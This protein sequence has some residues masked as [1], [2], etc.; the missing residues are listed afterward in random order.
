MPIITAD[1]SFQSEL[2]CP[3]DWQPEC[4]VTWL[5]DPDGDGTFELSLNGLPAGSYG[6]KATHGLSLTESYGRGGLPTGGVV[7]QH[8]ALADADAL[9]LTKNAARDA[10]AVAGSADLAVAAYDELGRLVDAT[11]ATVAPWPARC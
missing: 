11:K 10:A 1:G 6:V 3:A 8:P 9:V 7:R 5:Q 2:G 4:M